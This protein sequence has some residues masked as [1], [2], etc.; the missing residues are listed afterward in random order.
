MSPRR[1]VVAE[2]NTT[3]SAECRLLLLWRLG[4]SLG[5]PSCLWGMSGRVR[6]PRFIVLG[7]GAAPMGVD[8][9]IVHPLHP[10][11][12]AQAITVGAAAEARGEEKVRFYGERCRE[13]RWELCA[14]SYFFLRRKTTNTVNVHIV[15]W[16]EQQPSVRLQKNSTQNNPRSQLKSQDSRL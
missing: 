16:H 6:R 3:A 13:R 7:N 5:L 8:V 11:R 4:A 2:S 9:S 12:P 15:E 14:V 1:Y 10:S